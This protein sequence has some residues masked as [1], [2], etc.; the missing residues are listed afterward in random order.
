MDGYCLRW[1]TQV[2]KNISKVSHSFHRPPSNSTFP[3]YS[4]HSSYTPS[5]EQLS[6]PIK[7]Q[8]V[9]LQL[10]LYR[11]MFPSL[12]VYCLIS[13]LVHKSL[14]IKIFTHLVSITNSLNQS[15]PRHLHE[16]RAAADECGDIGWEMR[17]G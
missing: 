10:S 6:H 14:Q 1:E 17:R 16:R 13:A 7:K 2:S 9:Y 4:R 8:I 11:W 5:R 15:K 3:P 12:R